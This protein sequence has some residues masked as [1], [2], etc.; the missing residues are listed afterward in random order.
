M[1]CYGLLF[2]M[3]CGEQQMPLHTYCQLYAPVYWSR[4]DTRRTKEQID[5]N[6]R[7]WKSVC[8]NLPHSR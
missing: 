4:A 3:W 6:N 7:V 1:L 8:K 5:T 2:V